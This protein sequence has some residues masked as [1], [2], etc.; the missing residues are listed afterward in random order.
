MS[1]EVLPERMD[2]G[3]LSHKPRNLPEEKRSVLQCFHGW[4]VTV[5]VATFYYSRGFVQLKKH[6]FV[7]REGYRSMSPPRRRRVAAAVAVLAGL[8]HLA[9]VAFTASP[10]ER[11]L[12]M[13]GVLQFWALTFCNV[14]CLYGL[15][16]LV[17]DDL[18]VVEHMVANLLMFCSQWQLD[19]I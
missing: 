9:A 1:Q 7:S 12:D 17:V 15:C 18:L 4:W 6:M 13:P 3:T 8:G 14:I 10:R 16:Y 19:G 2:S 11:F 5:F